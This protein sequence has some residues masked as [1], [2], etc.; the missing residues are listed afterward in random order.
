MM[1]TSMKL[2]PKYNWYTSSLSPF[3]TDDAVENY[4]WL[5]PFSE[6]DYRSQ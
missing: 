5:V 3:E 4:V 6:S 1:K 2:D